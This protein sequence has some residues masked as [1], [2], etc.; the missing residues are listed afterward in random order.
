MKQIKLLHPISSLGFPKELALKVSVSETLWTSR[1]VLDRV[2]SATKLSLSTSALPV[3]YLSKQIPNLYFLPSIVSSACSCSLI[4]FKKHK[5]VTLVEIPCVKLQPSEDKTTAVSESIVEK[6]LVVSKPS[7]VL[8]KS[9]LEAIA[10]SSEIRDALNDK[11]LQELICHIDCSSN[12]EDELDKAMAEEAFRLFTDK[13][14]S[15]IN[16]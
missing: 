16:P 15:T 9:Q 5:G 13:I 1:W 3:T 8:Q 2:K 4:C 7:E 6:P 14:L 12:A 11:A 10:S